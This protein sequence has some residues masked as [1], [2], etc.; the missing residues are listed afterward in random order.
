MSDKLSSTI[1]ELATRPYPGEKQELA[2]AT[3]FLN[4]LS[5]HHFTLLGYRRYDLRK[6]S[7]DLELVPDTSS[8]LGLMN[9]AGKSQLETGLLLSNFS[10]SARREALD[11]SLLVLTKSSEKAEFIAQRMLIMSVLS[12]L[13]SKVMLLEKIG[14]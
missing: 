8:S 6:V 13:I 2:E 11:A 7:G 5:D 9:I 14:F 3:N 12:A 4:Y 1:S 10:D